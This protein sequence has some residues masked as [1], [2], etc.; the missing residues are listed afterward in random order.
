MR[1]FCELFVILFTSNY[2]LVNIFQ[3][4]ITMTNFFN[5]DNKKTFHIIL[6]LKITIRASLLF[7][8]LVTTLSSQ[9]IPKFVSY[10]ILDHSIQLVISYCFRVFSR[11]LCMV[12]YG[13]S[14]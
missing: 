8:L 4:K 5:M 13:S 12:F 9:H 10:S 7:A 14:K 2:L 6:L 1:I 11:V 3:M